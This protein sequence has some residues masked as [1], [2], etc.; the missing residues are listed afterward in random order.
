MSFLIVQDVSIGVGDLL[1]E[2]LSFTVGR[3]DRLGIVGNNG[4]GKTTL[5]RT[6]QK[7]ADAVKGTIV[8]A[9]G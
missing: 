9:P 4:A 7:T 5:F 2:G 1:A 6:L 8:H 3:G